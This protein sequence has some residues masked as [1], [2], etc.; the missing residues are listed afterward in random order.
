MARVFSQFKTIAIKFCGFI[1]WLFLD[2]LSYVM[3]MEIYFLYSNMSK[4]KIVIA[5]LR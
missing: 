1:K 2:F 3:E 5:A 4:W